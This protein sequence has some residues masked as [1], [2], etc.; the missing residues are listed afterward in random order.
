[1]AIKAKIQYRVT[2]LNV[3]LNASQEFMPPPPKG[4]NWKPESI[5]GNEMVFYTL[6]S[7]LAKA[8][9][10]KTAKVRRVLKR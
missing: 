6:W 5:S 7:R 1:M 3:P 10:A 2:R 8:K 4:D 9:T